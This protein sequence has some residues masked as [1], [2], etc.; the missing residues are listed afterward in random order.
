MMVIVC[1]SPDDDSTMNNVPL[2]AKLLSVDGRVVIAMCINCGKPI[3][4]GCKIRS[5]IENGQWL[6]AHNQCLPKPERKDQ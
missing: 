4:A 2:G 5:F 6:F 1:K 3:L